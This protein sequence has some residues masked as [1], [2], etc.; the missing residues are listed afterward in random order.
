M[1]TTDQVLAA[2]CR[3]L[4][5]WGRSASRVELLARSENLS[6]AV[7]CDDGSRF[8][9]RLHRPGYNERIELESE[10][11]WV[12]SLAG[13]GVAVPLAVA[14]AE[15]AHYVTVDVGGER[16]EAGLVAWVDG[17]P[18]A[19]LVG[20]SQADLATWFCQIGEMAGRIR[21]HT[22]QWEPPDWF[23]R[24]R[25]DADGLVGARPLWGRFWECA[26]LEPPVRDLL[27][28]ART[29][30]HARVSGLDDG[31]A[32]FGLIHADLNLGNLLLDDDRLTVI[33]F[34]DAGFGFHAYELAV[35]LQPLW[36]SPGY[37]VARTALL[38][39]YRS[40]HEIASEH[41]D[42]FVTVRSLMLVGWYCDRPEVRTPDT[43]RIV[44]GRAERAA[45]HLLGR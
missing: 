10:V 15:G 7:V 23:V 11:A 13:A 44:L 29:E 37:E 27:G 35:A 2:A 30:L 1:A 6:C 39:G 5:A 24:R 18:V 20:D 38:E 41:V 40:S 3:A 12:R 22:E 26:D 33:D 21:T 34:D 31:P 16:R 9:L 19:E 32:N 36:G 25:W 45:R 14:T 8:V 17:S 28:D 4:P 43:D 42:L